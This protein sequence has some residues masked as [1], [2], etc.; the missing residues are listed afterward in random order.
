MRPVQLASTSFRFQVAMRG[1]GFPITVLKSFKTS[2]LEVNGDD[3]RT[4]RR[5]FDLRNDVTFHDVPKRR[6]PI[7]R[8]QQPV[9]GGRGRRRSEPA[10]R[11]HLRHGVTDAP[12]NSTSNHHATPCT[13]RRDVTR[14]RASSLRDSRC[15]AASAAVAGRF[16]LGLRSLI[17]SLI[18][19]LFFLSSLK[20]KLE[21][22]RWR[23]KDLWVE[24]VH[25][26]LREHR[27]YGCVPRTETSTP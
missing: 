1:V 10:V 6:S 19:S 7:L 14:N 4:R 5:T 16:R 20:V 8:G 13:R 26:R 11:A 15:S 17:R 23:E 21:R 18:R 12:S 24:R 3:G 2:S 27:S 9:R 22:R 25:D